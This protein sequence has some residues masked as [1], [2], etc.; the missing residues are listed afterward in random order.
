MKVYKIIS[1]E[2]LDKLED[3]FSSLEEFEGFLY[4]IDDTMEDLNAYKYFR[5]RL[6]GTTD[7]YDLKGVALLVLFFQENMDLMAQLSRTL[8]CEYLSE[9][10]FNK[11]QDIDEFI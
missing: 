10:E 6:D 4:Q 7:R 11:R 8:E 5:E 3:C 9:E 1:K 2:A